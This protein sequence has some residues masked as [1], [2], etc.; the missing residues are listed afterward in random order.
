MVVS[1]YSRSAGLA[2]FCEK[3]GWGALDPQISWYSMFWL[4]VWLP[5]FM[6]PWILGCDDHPSWLKLIFCRLGW[7]K[8]T[9]QCSWW[10]N[11]M[12]ETLDSSSD[13]LLNWVKECRDHLMTVSA[14]S[15]SKANVPH[16]RTMFSGFKSIKSSDVVFDSCILWQERTPRHVE[17]GRVMNSSSVNFR[18]WPI[19]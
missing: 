7:R 16:P 13:F 2:G 18:V 4:V 1:A 8:T 17:Q 14:T 5:F 11:W 10:R 6:F 9:N 3:I 12:K 19:G 15:P